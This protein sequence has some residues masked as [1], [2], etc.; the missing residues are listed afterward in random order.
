MQNFVMIGQFIVGLMIIVGIHELGHLLFAKLFGMR[1]EQYMIGYPP[2][3]FGFK[4]GETEYALGG[5]PLGGAAKISGMIDESFDLKG[6]ASDPQPW[7]FR[8]K[9][10]WQRLLVILGGII[11]NVI[12]GI[13]IFTMLTYTL[14]EQ[15]LPKDELNKHGIV[16]TAL[17]KE[18]GFQEGD[19]IIGYNGQDFESYTDLFDPKVLLSD[20][21]YYTILRDGHSMNLKIDPSIAEKVTSDKASMWFVAP[22]CPFTVGQLNPDGGAQKAGLDSGDIILAV[23]GSPIKYLHQLKALLS[24]FSGTKVNITYKRADEEHTTLADIDANG[25]LGFVPEIQLRY[26]YKKYSFLASIPKGTKTAFRIVIDN[27]YGLKRIITGKLSFSKSIKGPIG[28]AKIFGK[29]FYWI[30]FWRIVGILSMV[31]ALMNCLPIPALDGGHAVIILY[32][33]ITGH[34]PSDKI[35]LRIQVVGVVI[36]LSLAT[37][38]IFNDLFRIFFKP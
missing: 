20:N 3:L 24:E 27:L 9:P 8:S 4:F 31:I 10:T 30:K 6:V 2:K 37:F 22:R 13:F 15:Y 34:K 36:L 17:G 19:K 35:L 11:F 16:P 12:S 1:V 33:M 28:I 29:E 32:E 14:G 38:T 5:V 26:T 18:I 7:E 25:L 21:S 23:N